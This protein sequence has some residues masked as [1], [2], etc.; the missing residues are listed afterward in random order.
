[1]QVLRTDDS[2]ARQ[3]RDAGAIGQKLEFEP[4]AG[5]TSSSSSR[6][7][8][9]PR[10]GCCARSLRFHLAGDIPPTRW[11]TLTSRIPRQPGNRRHDVPRHALD[12]GATAAS[13]EVAKAAQAAYGE[14]ALAAAACSRSATTP[15]ASPRAAARASIDR[16]AHGTLR[17]DAQGRVRRELEWVRIK[18]RR[19][20]ART[21]DRHV[22]RHHGP[23]CVAG[24]WIAADRRA[25]ENSACAFLESQGFT[26]VARNFL[27]RVGELDVCARAATAGDRR[28]RTRAED[29]IG[30]ARRQHRPRQTDAHRRHGGRCSSQHPELRRMPRALRRASW[31]AMARSNGS[32]HAFDA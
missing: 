20:A 31:C 26:I 15:S 12:A 10:R 19:P 4:R 11:A 16:R 7:R 29:A 25:A 8:Q 22:A 1:M 5:P 32:K 24:A 9:P 3:Q 13:A 17:M 18:A 6:P 30:G 2:S 14:S 21:P 23:T 28:S 27:R